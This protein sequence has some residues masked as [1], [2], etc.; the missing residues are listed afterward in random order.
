M[1]PGRDASTFYDPYRGR[2]PGKTVTGGVAHF[3]RSTTGYGAPIPSG[4]SD[5]SINNARIAL[6]LIWSLTDAAVV[7]DG[8]RLSRRGRDRLRVGQPPAVGDLEHA[9]M[10]D[11]VADAVE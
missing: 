3:V 4:W 1:H 11:D 2:V 6:M 8:R 5:A 9:V 7:G 10:L